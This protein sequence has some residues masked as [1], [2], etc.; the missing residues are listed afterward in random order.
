MFG[1][2]AAGGDPALDKAAERRAATLAEMA[3]AFLTE[4][5]DKKLKPG[6][7]AFYR[8]ILERIV[9]P[10]L[11]ATK[12]AAVTRA[13][14]ARLHSGL[15]ATP[16][17][18]NR[19]LAVLGALY[20][21]GDRC[22]YVPEGTNP[23]RRVQKYREARRERYLSVEE[24]ARLGEVLREAE[25]VGLPWDVDETRPTA[26]HLAGPERR[27]TVYGPHVTGAIRLLIL[28][29]CRV[30]EIL[31]LEWD[32]VDFERA[33]LFL[34]DSKTGRKVVM[35][36]AAALQVLASLPRVGRY[37]IPGNA[38]D[39]P[40]ADLKKPWSHVSRRAGLER[41]RLHDLR[42][43]HAATGAGLGLGL[44]IIG[45]LL[46]HTQASTTQRPAGSRCHT[47]GRRRGPG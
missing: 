13:D 36:G 22:G 17:Q 4:H 2:V 7:R 14:V 10:E 23:A 34:P 5:V 46:G 41:V 21:W 37:V 39:R 35:L 19:V 15:S 24:L 32:H 31:D 30:R 9:V 8:D 3:R 45:K 42:H 40:R 28:T 27:R 26:K 43:T 1:V 38:P 6:T 44:P 16:Y 29:G 11:G 12:A 33:A 47:R 20:T 25:T 18:A